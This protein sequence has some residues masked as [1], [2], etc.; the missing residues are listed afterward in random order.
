MP[1]DEEENQ[2]IFLSSRSMTKNLF[3]E[4]TIFQAHSA[5]TFLLLEVDCQDMANTE[6][7]LATFRAF[8]E[9]PLPSSFFCCRDR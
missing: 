7:T 2:Q 6:G 8:L 5:S 9:I 4:T 1:P 3:F